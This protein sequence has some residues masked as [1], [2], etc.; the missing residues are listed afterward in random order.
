MTTV[1]DLDFG[2]FGLKDNDG[3]Y[4]IVVQLDNNV[5]YDDEVVGGSGANRAEY[6]LTGLPATTQLTVTVAD[7]TLSRDGGGPSPDFTIGSF[8]D[9]DP[10][11][12]GSGAGTL[13]I[14]GT[15]TTSGTSDH[16]YTGPYSGTMAVTVSW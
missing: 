6:A 10:L 12:D 14:G 16:Y 9:N 4:T 15:L 5:I 8:T 13:Y 2:T 7:S 3:A 11:T 1:V